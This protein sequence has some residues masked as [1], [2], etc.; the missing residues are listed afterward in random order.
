MAVSGI[1]YDNSI[2]N[3]APTEKNKQISPQTKNINFYP[4]TI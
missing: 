2:P 4:S 1:K 3:I